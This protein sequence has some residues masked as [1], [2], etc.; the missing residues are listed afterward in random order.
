MPDRQAILMRRPQSS[1]RAIPA[2]ELRPDT[3]DAA[4]ETSDADSA[5]GDYKPFWK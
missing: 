4:G 2:S 3:A 1:D 5:G